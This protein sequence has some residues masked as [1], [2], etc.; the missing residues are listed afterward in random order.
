MRRLWRVVL[1]VGLAALVGSA[2]LLGT[3]EVVRGEV[4]ELRDRFDAE[5][6]ALDRGGMPFEE[7]AASRAAHES[8]LNPK[9]R[10]Q[11]QLEIGGYV[12]LMAGLVLTAAGAV[13][14]GAKRTKPQTADPLTGRE[15]EGW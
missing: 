2:V 11:G 5:E 1:Y 4:L 6:E 3:T 12:A 7:L 15:D 9:R 10:L 14:P 13:A 8:V